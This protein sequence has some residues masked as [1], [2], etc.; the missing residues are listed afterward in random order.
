[1]QQCQADRYFS[2]PINSMPFQKTEIDFSIAK[3]LSRLVS[4]YLAGKE[5]LQP[6]YSFFPDNTG[7]EKIIQQ[8]KS[9]T[10]NRPVLVEVL[11]EQNYDAGSQIRKNIESLQEENTFTVTTGHQ[12]NLFTGPLYF[13]Y[14]ILTTIRLSQ[15]L[16]ENFPEYNFV[17]VYWMASEDHDIEEINHAYIHG[18]KITWQPHSGGPAGRLKCEG[19]ET[20]LAESAAILG[21]TERANELTALLASAYSPGHTLA[22]AARIIVNELFGRYGL[23]VLDPDDARL[24]KLFDG[25]MKAELSG[26]ASHQKTGETI[27]D[28]EKLGYEAQVHPREINLFY[29]SE[30]SRERIVK[31]NGNYSV[32]NT[33]VRWNESALMKEL[34]THPERFSPNVVLRP[35]YQEIILPN[36]AYVGGPAEIAYWLEYKS[37]FAHFHTGFPLLILRSC[38]ML[39]D[40][41]S[42]AKMERLGMSATDIFK[43]AGELAKDFVARNAGAISLDDEFRN[44]SAAYDSIAAKT[45]SLDATLSKSAEAEKQRQLNALSAFEEKIMRAQKKKHETELRQVQKL[46][47]RFFPGGVLQE[48]VENFMPHYVANGEPFFDD[49]LD[50]INPMDLHFLLISK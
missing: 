39:L 19:M 26:Q 44:V 25:V 13:I 6:F 1:M 45:A 43:P 4:D 28:L 34:E 8:R 49:L 14:K 29:L 12:L 5:S 31:E 3:S 9:D 24:K 20:V 30:N 46:K 36:L 38:A 16:K 22:D 10:I 42:R 35:V 41:S 27:L 21:E 2:P 48:R 11:K 33:A 17:P 15:K 32:L 37:M 40:E 18:K 23:V 47:E 7:F 50:A